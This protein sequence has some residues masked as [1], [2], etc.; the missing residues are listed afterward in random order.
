VR[1]IADERA[2]DALLVPAAENGGFRV[3]RKKGV[4][5]GGPFY[6]ALEF[7]GHEGERVLVKPDPTDMGRV[8]VYLATGEFLAVAVDPSAPEIDRSEFSSRLRA[9]QKQILAEASKA[10]KKSAKEQAVGSIGEEIMDAALAR[11]ENVVELP[12][13]TAPY[14]TEALRQAARAVEARDNC[15][16][17]ESPDF[18]LRGSDFT[19]LQ[20]EPET[21]ETAEIVPLFSSAV[22]VYDYFSRLRKQRSLTP[23]ELAQVKA[24][25]EESRQVRML[26]EM[27]G[28]KEWVAAS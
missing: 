27:E 7:A 16:R 6:A 11:L 26:A 18:V 3:I 9:K 22:E 12:R 24:A 8:Y 20:D 1:T 14:S 28:D 25:Y 15:D 13:A 21:A 23:G 19:S 17:G 5:V 4:E 10:L 2:L